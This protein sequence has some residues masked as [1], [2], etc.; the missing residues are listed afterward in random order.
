M[1]TLK[2]VFALPPANRMKDVEDLVESLPLFI[3]VVGTF[4]LPPVLS[5]SVICSFFFFLFPPL[6]L[7][8]LAE[9][10]FKMYLFYSLAFFPF[11]ISPWTHRFGQNLRE[12][13]EK[14]RK[15]AVERKNKK[16]IQDRE[17]AASKRKQERLQ[18]D[19]TYKKKNE[20]R[21]L[22]KKQTRMVLSRSWSWAVFKRGH[23]MR[24]SWCAVWHTVASWTFLDCILGG[25]SNTFSSKYTCQRLEWW[26]TAHERFWNLEWQPLFVLL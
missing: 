5:L 24:R 26:L 25:L 2:F 23:K 7:Y 18:D 4:R 1:Q 13:A 6:S 21:A 19:P 9:Q 12:K 15:A 8:W 17:E 22:K 20:K 11:C 16:N 3:D 10:V 14:A